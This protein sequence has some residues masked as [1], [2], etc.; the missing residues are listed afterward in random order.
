M[1]LPGR[2]LSF[3]GGLKDGAVDQRGQVGRRADCLVYTSEPLDEPI[4]I[5]G[6]PAMDVFLSSDQRDTDVA[7]RLCDVHPDGRSMLLTDGIQRMKFRK[8]LSRETP[9]DPGEAYR[10][11]VRL[12]PTSHTLKL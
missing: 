12:V 6:A 2:A 8:S 4:A 7:V 5:A 11:T 9:M 3:W 10:A 1:N